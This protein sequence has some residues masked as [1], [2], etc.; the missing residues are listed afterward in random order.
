MTIKPILLAIVIIPIVGLIGLLSWAIY[1]SSDNPSGFLINNQ[2]GQLDIETKDAPDFT[3]NTIDGD[4]LNLSDFQGKIVMIDF[5][6]TWCPPCR[7]EAPVLSEA[8]DLYHSENVEFIGIAIWDRNKDVRLF[9]DTHKITY[10]N[11]LDSTGEIAID[12]GVRGIPEKYFIDKL[13]RIS[14]KISGPMDRN[15]LHNILDDLLN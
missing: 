12:Y 9:I 11:G 3:L 6:C 7:T 8:Y 10:P 14:H 4:V 5:W 2:F 15:A 13:G 1:Q